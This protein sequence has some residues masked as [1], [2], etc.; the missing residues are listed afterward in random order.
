MGSKIDNVLDA[1]EKEKR[2]IELEFAYL[3]RIK[4]L[5]EEFLA[6]KNKKI[7]ESFEKSVKRK[8]KRLVRKAGRTEIRIE[9]FQKRTIALLKE[10]RSYLPSAYH[11]NLKDSDLNKIMIYSN[12]LMYYVSRRTGELYKIA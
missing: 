1:I 10:L 5:L 12:L 6:I 2:F 4:Q 8:C 3:K 7:S 9:R 11:Y